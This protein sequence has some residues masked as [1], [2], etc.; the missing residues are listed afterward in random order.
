S[1]SASVRKFAW[2][3][4]KSCASA[5]SKLPVRLSR[6]MQSDTTALQLRILTAADAVAIASWRYREPYLVYDMPT[7]AS[8]LAALLDPDHQ[9][10]AI[11]R[12]DDDLV[13]YF[14]RRTGCS[15]PWLAL[16]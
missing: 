14:W 12:N 10:H 13:A 16:R 1:P 7:G 4:R 6:A 11:G 3:N 15:R 8:T 9:Y 2:W 5:S